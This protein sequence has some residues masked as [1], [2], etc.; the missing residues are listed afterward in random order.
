MHDWITYISSLTC[1]NIFYAL[2]YCE[3]KTDVFFSPV[4]DV[5]I[6]TPTLMTPFALDLAWEMSPVIQAE[7]VQ[8]LATGKGVLCSGQVSE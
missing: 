2:Y 5:S 6:P 8:L 7:A 1:K 3:R 4:L